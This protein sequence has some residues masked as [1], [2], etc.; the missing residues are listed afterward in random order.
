M[1]RSQFSEL[2]MLTIGQDKYFGKSIGTERKLPKGLSPGK[3]YSMRGASTTVLPKAG[4]IP[5]TSL[6]TP[7]P[8]KKT[9]LTMISSYHDNQNQL[10]RQSGSESALGK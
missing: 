4:S 8:E 5:S 3:A 7:M 2:Q 10:P 9:K 1:L 6:I